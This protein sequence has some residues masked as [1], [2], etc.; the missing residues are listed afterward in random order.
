MN[1]ETVLG[2][3][4]VLKGKLKR[5]FADLTDDDLIYMKGRE[6]E[7][8]GRLQR[9]TGRTRTELER[10]IEQLDRATAAP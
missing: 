2:N 7:L 4:H 5:Q 6:E 9:R 1:R 8:F 10:L 3:W